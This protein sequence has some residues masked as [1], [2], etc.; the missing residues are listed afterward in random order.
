MYT[1]H[2][3]QD[4]LQYSYPIKRA[5]ELYLQTKQIVTE[6]KLHLLSSFTTR[7]TEKFEVT[8]KP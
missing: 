5:S 8:Q 4:Q 2:C 6:K 1:V 7:V 3:L